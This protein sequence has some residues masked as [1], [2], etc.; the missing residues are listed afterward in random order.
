MEESAGIIV[1]IVEIFCGFWLNPSDIITDTVRT[2]SSW[3]LFDSIVEFGTESINGHGG[4]GC[5]ATYR[6]IW[7]NKKLKQILFNSI[8]DLCDESDTI[9]VDFLFVIRSKELNDLHSY[10]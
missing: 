6:R 3:L 9:N 7:L 4:G 2:L 1:A 10:V 5:W 8:S